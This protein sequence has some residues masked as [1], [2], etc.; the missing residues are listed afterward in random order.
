MGTER[1]MQLR[2]PVALTSE[3][4]ETLWF[5]NDL[6]TFKATGE[7]TGGAFLLIEELARKG[8]I[9]PLHVHP[10]EVETFYLLQGEVRFHLDGTETSLGVGGFVSVPPGVPHAYLVASEI[11]RTLILITPGDGA[12]ESF[13]RAASEPASGRE[14]PPERPL[15]I[16][17]IAAAAR[18]TGAVEILGPPPFVAPPA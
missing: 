1:T 13:F 5:N 6:L 9:T 2:E 3:E 15:D 7:E 11:A 18:A 16:E 8:K 4:G 12:M 14:L 17:R 10:H